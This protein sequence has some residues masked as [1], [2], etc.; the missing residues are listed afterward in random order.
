MTESEK[1]LYDKLRGNCWNNVSDTF[2]YQYI[3]DKRADKF[4]RRLN[5][6]KVLGIIV[7]AAI[8]ATALGYGLDNTLLKNLMNIA[9][10]VTTVQ[11]LVS[12]LAVIYKWDEELSYSFEASH[13][14]NNLYRKYKR[15]AEFPPTDYIEFSRQYY[16]IDEE[17]NSRVLQDSKHNIKE[18][19]RRMGMRWSLREHQKECVGCKEVP[20]SINS[21]DC[22][23]CG[24]FYSN[25]QLLKYI[26][27]L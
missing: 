6:L 22:D 13:A 21:T 9:I 5:W 3:F 24:K 25:Y 7:P 23:V 15:L 16:L 20:Q 1:D 27:T 2:G 8:G 10:P 18:R 14:H 11:F 12:V 26:Q 4:G 19:E 17:H